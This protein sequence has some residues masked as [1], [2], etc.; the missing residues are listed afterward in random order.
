MLGLCKYNKGNENNLY[1]PKTRT[2]CVK[3][4]ITYEGAQLYDKLPRDIKI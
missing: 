1:L 4:C 2:N 3:T